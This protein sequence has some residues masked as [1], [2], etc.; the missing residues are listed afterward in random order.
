MQP[1]TQQ[2]GFVFCFLVICGESWC[3][4]DFEIGAPLGRGKFGS[5][6]MA[7]EKKTKYVVALKVLHKRQITQT[8]VKHQLRREIEIQYGLR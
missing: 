4:D 3:L 1:T 7:R 6:F 8:K 5:V 2:K